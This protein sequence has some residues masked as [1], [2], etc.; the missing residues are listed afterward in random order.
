MFSITVAS[1]TESSPWDSGV[2]A[3]QPVVGHISAT[4]GGGGGGVL[5][6]YK[7]HA[8]QSAVAAQLLRIK[9]PGK[10][11]DPITQD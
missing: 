2:A 7:A 8:R 9:N 11:L 3:S 6:P 5:Q 1:A 4:G 10:S